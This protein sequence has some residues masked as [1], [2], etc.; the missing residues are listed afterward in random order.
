MEFELE[1]VFV[2]SDFSKASL[3]I[4]SCCCF[5]DENKWEEYRVN[6]QERKCPDLRLCTIF[7]NN[8]FCK[9]S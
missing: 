6:S 8:E 7:L 3:D 2:K 4:N 5:N 1:G 9:D